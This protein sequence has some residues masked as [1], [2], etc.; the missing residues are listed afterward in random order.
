M[1]LMT[2]FYYIKSI[3]TPMVHFLLDETAEVISSINSSNA[4]EVDLLLLKPY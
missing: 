1:L 2:L 4:I 3:N